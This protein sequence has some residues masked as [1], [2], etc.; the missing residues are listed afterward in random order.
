MPVL[1]HLLGPDRYAAIGLFLTIQSLASLLDIGISSG[2]ARQS[3]WLTGANAGAERFASLLRAF[4]IPYLMMTGVVLLAA[5]LGG[6]EFLELAFGIDPRS[7]GLDRVAAALLFGT[8]VVRLP[9]GIYFG[10]LLGR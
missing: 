6:F 1:L 2:I 10:Y 9:L 5:I 3:A 8:V 4:E 7:V